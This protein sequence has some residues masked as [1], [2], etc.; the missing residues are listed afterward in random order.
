M[1]FP[2][3]TSINTEMT[4]NLFSRDVA[5]VDVILDLVDNSIDA[6]RNR[7]GK[8]GQRIDDLDICFNGF[9]I[10]L[11]LDPN[12]FFIKDN[13]SGIAGE[14]LQEDLFYLG[15]NNTQQHAIGA[16]GVGFPRACWK[17]AKE[18][19]LVTDD[20]KTRNR[21]KFNCQHFNDPENPINAEQSET[22]GKL[23]LS[24]EL[25]HLK[26]E[27]RH[28]FG[29]KNWIANL[30]NKIAFA[31]CIPLSKG[32]SIKVGQKK[33][34]A[35]RPAINKDVEEIYQT[36]TFKTTEGVWV[37]LEVGM[38]EG[39]E[40]TTAKGKVASKSQQKAINECGWYIVCNGRVLAHAVRDERLF[41]SKWHTQHLGFLG[42]AFFSCE[43]SH[44]LPWNTGKSDLT[45]DKASFIEASGRILQISGR[46]KSQKKKFLDS[47]K[48][49][50]AKNHQTEGRTSAIHSGSA[51]PH[52]AVKNSPKFGIGLTQSSLES[53]K[54]IQTKL[55]ELNN[56]KLCELYGSLT[57]INFQH[58]P[59]LFIV[60]SCVLEI[61]CLQAGKPLNDKRTVSR[62]IG[63]E[64][65]D[66][67]KGPKDRKTAIIR[68]LESI[69]QNANITKHDNVAAAFD[70]KQLINDMNSID[71]LM[72]LLI[73][74]AIRIKLER[75]K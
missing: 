50:E 72:V 63:E 14:R 27:A 43:Q 3:D 16:F 75:Q 52:Q 18:G 28:L 55:G 62:F 74:D 56:Q 10:E 37:K 38:H 25:R 36:D 12:L 40:V 17:I 64:Y 33:V 67:G 60:A 6:A 20:G 29:D 73:E 42:W 70:A 68:S 46:F 39:Y 71:E 41:G 26:P 8:T 13:C 5:L 61:L 1:Q 34:E 48:T 4:Y 47:K 15:S 11:S 21:V 44:L 31:Y 35:N 24:L 57:M 45:E 19:L 9:E 51:P 69:R 54:N 66:K 53:S 32:L 58:C 7:I 30:H 22:Q 49:V 23:E 65:F 2:V 59:V